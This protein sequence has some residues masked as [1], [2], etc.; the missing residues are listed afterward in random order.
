MHTRRTAH[1]AVTGLDGR[2]YVLGGEQS[3]GEFATTL[4]SAEVFDPSTGGWTMLPN[5]P[6]AR[7]SLAAAVDSQ[8]RIYAIGGSPDRTIATDIVEVYDPSKNTWSSFA[9][10]RTE[11]FDFGAWG[12][13]VVAGD[14][15][16]PILSST[17]YYDYASAQ[18]KP[19]ASLSGPRTSFA[20][21]ADHNGRIYVIGGIADGNVPLWM[22]GTNLVDTYS[23]TEDRWAVA[24]SMPTPRQSLAAATGHD[25]RIFALG[26]S[27]AQNGTLAD[28]ATVEVYDPT[29]NQWAAFDSLTTPRSGLAA[30]AGHDGRI[31]AIGGSDR[32]TV[33]ACS[34]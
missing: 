12:L 27:I 4:G 5:M 1:A 13:F 32:D 23:P 28:A 21:T 15:T 22:A 29:T 8:G 24:A 25:G 34:P 17:E 31:Y 18:W 2:I 26:G 7:S 16:S 10:L 20:I 19:A 14:S 11:R 33:E 6:T 9:S 30:A 3:N